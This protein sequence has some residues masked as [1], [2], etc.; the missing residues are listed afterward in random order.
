MLH[1]QK[2][3]YVIRTQS[4]PV[5]NSRSRILMNDKSSLA[6]L[7]SI[8]CEHC[9]WNC[10]LV[11]LKYPIN[12]AQIYWS[13]GKMCSKVHLFA[14]TFYEQKIGFSL[15]Q[16]KA[17]KMTDCAWDLTIPVKR[18]KRKHGCFSV[19]TGYDIKMHPAL[20]AVLQRE[21]ENL[22]GLVAGLALQPP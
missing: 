7:V 5:S 9:I 21:R 4:P 19:S 10:I 13:P 17:Y 20:Q 11:I 18:I 22:G 15:Q 16:C 8:C 1:C 3:F 14:I 12:E 6:N 2:M